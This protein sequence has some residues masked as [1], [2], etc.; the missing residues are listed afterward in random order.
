MQQ[1]P[2]AM[3][4]KWRIRTGIGLPVLFVALALDAQ[5]MARPEP[6][7]DNNRVPRQE[8]RQPARMLAGQSQDRIIASAEKRHV[9][10]VIKVEEGNHKGRRI[11]VL[12]LLSKEGK[13]ST[14]RVDAENGQEL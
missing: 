9:A 7:A 5:A 8:L 13:V 2:T 10:K 11:Y 4:R 14:V 12:R 6:G 3:R 1:Q